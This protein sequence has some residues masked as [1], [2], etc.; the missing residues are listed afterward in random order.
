MNRVLPPLNALR[1]FEAA[2]RLGSFKEAAAELHVT[3]GAVSQHVRLL[4]EWLG[5]SLFE[6][7]NRRVKLTPAAQAYLKEIGPLFEQLSRATA[8]Y[9]VPETVSRTLSV[10]APATFTLRWLVPRL[11]RFRAEHPDVDVNMATSN[12][13]LESLKTTTS[14]SGAV[15]TRST[16]TRCG[17]SSLRNGFRSVVRRCCSECRFDCPATCNNT[18]CCTR[19][20]FRGFG[21]T[22][23][24]ARSLLA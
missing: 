10:N 6:R 16:A 17:L 1:A 8:R 18:P 14:S 15:R 7:H 20:V 9:G 12:R 22:G 11:A 24:R 4:E 21:L 5:A 23:W 13:P 3:Q 19:R 2:G